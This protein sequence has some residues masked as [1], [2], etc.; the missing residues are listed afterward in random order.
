MPIDLDQVRSRLK[1]LQN[2]TKKQDSFWKPTPG[3]HQVRIVPYK[4]DRDNPFIELLF[5]Y[6]IGAKPYLSPQ[7]FGRPD[8]IVEF[9]EGLKASGNKEDY[10]QGKQLEPKLRTFVPMVVRGKENEGVKFWGFG[11][12]VYQELLGLIADPDYGDITDL[13]SGH[14]ITV[15]F[16]SAEQTGKS[17]PSTTIRPRPSKT[18]LVETKEQLTSLFDTQKNILDIY[19]EPTYEDL[20]KVLSE[21]LHGGSDADTSDGSGDVKEKETTVKDFAS[22]KEQSQ[23]TKSEAPVTAT[24]KEDIEKDLDKLFEN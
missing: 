12:T 23:E 6:N 13:G 22:A 14:D 3:T 8:P 15:E 2:Q 11:K 18:K 21:W 1:I 9:A 4:F 17:F 10:K 5:H 19:K 16:K 20:E 24:S 7:S